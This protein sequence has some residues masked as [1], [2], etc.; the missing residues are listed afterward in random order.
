MVGLCL[1]VFLSFLLTLSF[2]GEL[3]RRDVREG[4]EGIDMYLDIGLSKFL[5]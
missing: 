2:I 3:Y 1:D 5:S 4:Q